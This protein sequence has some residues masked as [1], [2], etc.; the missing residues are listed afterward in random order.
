[1]TLGSGN[2]SLAV[3]LPSGEELN[4]WL[5]VNTIEFY[6][7]ISILYGTLMEFCTQESCPIMSAGPKYE[8]LWADGQNVKTPLKVSACEYIDYLMTWVEAQI[9]NETLFP[10]QIG[11]LLINQNLFLVYYVFLSLKIF[12]MQLRSYLKDY[13]EFMRI[14]IIH[15]FNIQ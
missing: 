10:C 7:E 14:C 8:Y 12:Q 9:N 13:L 3:E 15:I 4:E 2:M 5:A 11:N 6:N 1:M